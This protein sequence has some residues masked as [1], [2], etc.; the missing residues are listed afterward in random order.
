MKSLTI[1]G[2]PGSIGTQTLDIVR[3]HPEDF[4]VFALAA[5]K[6]AGLL[7]AQAREFLPKY[8]VLYNAKKKEELQRE[9][10]GTGISVL[11]GME[12]LIQVSEDPETDFVLGAI[13]GMIGIRPTLSAILKGKEIGIANK[14]TLVTAGH[15]LM[16]LVESK[17]VR[18]YPVDSEHSAIFQCLRGESE[19]TVEKILLTCSGGPFRGKKKEELKDITP[20]MALSHPNWKMGAKITIDSSTLI[21]KALEVMEAHWLFH[22]DYDRI[23][24]LVQPR[25]VVH[26]MVQFTDGGVMAQLGTPDMHLPIQYAL[27]GGTRET[28][29]GPRLDFNALSDIHFETPDTE[30]FE[31]LPLGI[32]CGKKGGNAP[33]IFN[34][35]NETAVSLFL[36]KKIS[37]PEIITCIRK[38]L[39]EVPFMKTPDLSEILATEDKVRKVLL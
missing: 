25:S 26:S 7:A 32:E 30:V 10:F 11:T 2:S 15:L 39:S 5:N 16:P 8:V 34:A 1:L 3:K 22:V 36:K 4:R 35:A 6:S 17:R 19:K 14:E 31:G 28:L 24:V 23:E 21:N 20:E 27:Y 29:D 33:T 37:Y 18:L 9:L 38:A 12:G 13:S